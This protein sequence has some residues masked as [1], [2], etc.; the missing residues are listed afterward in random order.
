MSFVDISFEKFAGINFAIAVIQTLHF[1]HPVLS[2]RLST[3]L[4]LLPEIYESLKLQH[5][6]L[7]IHKDI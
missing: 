3:F 5:C 6:F 7:Q 1:W 4:Y 2:C